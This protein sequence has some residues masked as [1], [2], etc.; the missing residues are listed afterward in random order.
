[1]VETTEAKKRRGRTSRKRK[2]I[3]KAEATVD[4]KRTVKAA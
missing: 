4:Q 2:E 3:L 1:M